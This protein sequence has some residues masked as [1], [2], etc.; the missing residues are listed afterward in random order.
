MKH[1]AKGR[2]GMCLALIVSVMAVGSASAEESYGLGGQGVFIPAW[3]F[4]PINNTGGTCTLSYSGSWYYRANGS[5]SRFFAHL[6][7]PEGANMTYFSAF[8]YDND[9][10][11]N[12]GVGFEKSSAYYGSS[13]SGAHMPTGTVY[14]STTTS[15]AST[16]YVL[17]S[18][19]P[20]PGGPNGGAIVNDTYTNSTS[21]HNDYMLYMDIPASTDLKVRGVWVF[22]TR[23]IAPA[24][25][26]ASFADVPTSHPFFNEVQQLSK[27]GITQGCGGGNYCPDSPVTRGQMAAFLSRTLGLHWDYYTDAP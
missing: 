23:Q 22:W 12:I 16:D 7:L 19:Y 13:A 27:A 14:T 20:N 6:A 4:Q 10:S 18:G 21:Y 11:N 17:L 3:E 15:G 8:V 24:P 1:Y 9:A 26:V 2:M 25:T 5:C